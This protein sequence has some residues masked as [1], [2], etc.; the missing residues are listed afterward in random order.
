MDP[1]LA[2]DGVIAVVLPTPPVSVVY[3]LRDVPVAVSGLADAP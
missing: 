1:A 3:H 2:V